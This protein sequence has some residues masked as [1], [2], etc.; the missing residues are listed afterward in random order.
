MLSR[1]R[2][3]IDERL[4]QG[5][6]LLIYGTGSLAEQCINQNPWI[7]PRIHTFVVS[8]SAEGLFLGLPVVGIEEC[9]LALENCFFIIASSYHREIAAGLMARGLMPDQHFIQIYQTIDPS[10]QTRRRVNGVEVGKYS[11]GYESF[12]FSGSLVEKV[13][14]FCSINNT[15]RI[16]EFNHPLDAITTHPLL[17][18]AEGEKLGY[19]GVPG[20]LPAE[21]LMDIYAVPSNGPIVIGNDVWIGANAVVLPG[22]TIG[23]GAV[24]GAGAVVTK[25]VPDYA[26]VTGIPARV[27]RY[28]FTDNEI[29]ILKKVQWWQ[30]SDERI[31]EEAPLIK[32]PALFFERY[33]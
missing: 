5:K 32:T 14:A 21:A 19:E 31:R 30:W 17:Y 18:V 4:S 9:S 12:C 13:G 28:R 27:A 8:R 25:D 20:L 15:A 3:L 24:I 6:T 33:A 10:T 23:D 2:S 11:Y 29:A 26:I 22:V 16:G 7:L 1:F